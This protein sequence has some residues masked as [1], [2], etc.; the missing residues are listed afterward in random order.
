MDES[1]II[2]AATAS[3]R[4][5]LSMA[6]SVRSCR[7]DLRTMPIVRDDVAAAADADATM[8]HTR[9]HRLR[10]CRTSA[11]AANV[12]VDRAQIVVA[13]TMRDDVVD[14]PCHL[15]RTV[16]YRTVHHSRR[17][18]SLVVADDRMHPR[19]YRR[20]CRCW[21]S[22]TIV[23]TRETARAAEVTTAGTTMA[24]QAK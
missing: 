13:E 3:I 17:S 7:F 22:A 24:E 19:S 2:S 11:V 15:F 4:C 6:T 20:R 18:K 9:W 12:V 1:T 21:P 23:P 10:Y 8:S 14:R 16:V 5:A